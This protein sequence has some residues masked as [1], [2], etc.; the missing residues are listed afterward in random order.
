MRSRLVIWGTNAREEKVLLAISL[1]PDDNN[2][3]IWAIPE[4][5]ITEEYYNQLMNSWREGAEVAIP[6]SAEHRVT[7]LTVSESILP[8]DLKV[9]R[10]DMIQRAQ[11]EWHFV[12]LSSKLYKN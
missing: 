1:N 7:E 5:D 12:V 8:E 9:E 10:G 6:A 3:D 2:I 11:M 4:K